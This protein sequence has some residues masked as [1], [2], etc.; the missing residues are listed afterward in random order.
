MPESRGVSSLTKGQLLRQVR[1]CSN[2]CL[3]SSEWGDVEGNGATFARNCWI[4]VGIAEGSGGQFNVICPIHWLV[5][6]WGRRIGYTISFVQPLT[7]TTE[8]QFQIRSDF[9]GCADLGHATCLVGSSRRLSASVRANGER[10]QKGFFS[11]CWIKSP[12]DQS[13]CSGRSDVTNR[14]EI[15]KGKVKQNTKKAWL[16]NMTDSRFKARRSPWLDLDSNINFDPVEWKN[17][18]PINSLRQLRVLAFSITLSFVAIVSVRHLW[19]LPIIGLAIIAAVIQTIVTES[20]WPFPRPASQAYVSGLRV[21][22]T[23]KCFTVQFSPR[24]T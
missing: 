5:D 1:G 22:P 19:S 18:L 17:L 3:F 4:L 16:F 12:P 11:L 13:C 2:T 15:R 7:R 23:P 8:L 10:S 20:A 14:N 6:S 24:L 21:H 9:G